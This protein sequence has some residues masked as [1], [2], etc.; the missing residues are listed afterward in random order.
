MSLGLSN[1]EDDRTILN[2][3]QALEGQERGLTNELIRHGAAKT[4]SLTNCSWVQPGRG[5]H[6]ATTFILES[7]SRN[8]H[9]T[10]PKEEGVHCQAVE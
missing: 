1:V 2:H 6:G 9:S 7:V 4:P 3:D 10:P 8:S 5:S